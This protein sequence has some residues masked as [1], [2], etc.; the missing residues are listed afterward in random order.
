MALHEQSVGGSDEWYTPEHVFKA[1]GCNFD[2]DVASPGHT[3]TPWIPAAKFIT[4][5]SLAHE[6]R[7]FIW[8]N[9]PFGR[10]NGLAPWLE[11]FVRHSD[12]VC[13]VPDRTS[14]PWWQEWMPQMDLILQ[15]SGK[16]HFVPGN[17]Q[18][19]GSPAQG[20]T[21]GA[22]GDRGVYAL[23]KAE[24]NGL[25]SLWRRSAPSWFRPI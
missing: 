21:L 24:Y 16:I 9:P 4:S 8:M 12:G 5:E 11:K 10:R 2:M 3:L 17:G 22:L 23:Y 13:L 20:T 25:G 15:V 1:M 6:W 7:G 14:A 19:S 18:P